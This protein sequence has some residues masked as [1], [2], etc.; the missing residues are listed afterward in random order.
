MRSDSFKRFG[1]LQIRTSTQVSKILGISRQ[2]VHQAER[3]AF[4]RIRD[5]MKQHAKEMGLT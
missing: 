4:R 2:A 3:R 5:G 1:L